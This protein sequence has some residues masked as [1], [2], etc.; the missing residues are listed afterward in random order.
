MG[1]SDST[2]GEGICFATWVQSLVSSSPAS[3]NSRVHSQN[4]DLNISGC[5]P[6]PSPQRKRKDKKIHLALGIMQVPSLYFSLVVAYAPRLTKYPHLP[7]CSQLGPRYFSLFLFGVTPGNVQGS[8]LALCSG[9]LP[10]SNGAGWAYL[11]HRLKECQLCA[12]QTSEPL[13]SLSPLTPLLSLIQLLKFVGVENR[14]RKTPPI[15]LEI[16]GD[17]SWQTWANIWDTEN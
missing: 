15:D 10:N 8:L 7:L 1:Q 4:S 13:L 9:I 17:Y 16:F 5:G 6:S 12:K 11:I 14:P 3:G 2:V